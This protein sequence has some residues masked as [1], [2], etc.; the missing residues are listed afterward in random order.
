M[1]IAC[2]IKFVPNIQNFKYDYEKNV[3]IR[4]N[5][6]MIL[7][8]DDIQALNTALTI[9]EQH[10]ATLEVITMAPA[11]IMPYARDIVRLGVHKLT[12]LCDKDFAGSDTYATSKIIST[13]ISQHKYDIVITGTHSLDGGTA[14][15]PAQIAHLLGYPQLSNIT[16]VLELSPHR[17]Q[18]QTETDTTTSTYNIQLP[19]VLSFIKQ[20]KTKLP[21]IKYENFTKDVDHQINILTNNELKVPQ[22]YIGLNGSKT[23]VKKTYAQ[24]SS[25]KTHTTFVTADEQGIATLHKF[26]VD[27]G[28]L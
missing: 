7:N 8:P 26:L 22:E 18:V 19:A 6:R 4:E 9:T 14:H 23:K 21:F 2:L 17:A 16:Q 28:Y 15:T 27:K 24:Q 10:N 20:A 5:S 11:T 12:I 3:I 1:K 13:Y 25:T